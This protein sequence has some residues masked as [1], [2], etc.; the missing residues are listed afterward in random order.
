MEKIA[1]NIST[2]GELGDAFKR[3]FKSMAAEA[4]AYYKSEPINAANE[5]HRL[6]YNN[7]MIAAMNPA[8][9]ASKA[10]CQIAAPPAAV[11]VTTDSSGELI[12]RCRHAPCHEW[13]LDGKKL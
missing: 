1:E 5:N 12:I 6:D 13:G 2:H 8:L 11:D 4:S 7:A 10:T 9:F 3:V